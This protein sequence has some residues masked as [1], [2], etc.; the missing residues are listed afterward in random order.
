[1]KLRTILKNG[2][3]ISVVLLCGSR[4]PR[5]PYAS[6]ISLYESLLLS[7]GVLCC[8]LGIWGSVICP[9]ALKRASDPERYR[10]AGAHASEVLTPLFLSL[11]LFTGVTLIVF[12]APL[13]RG[14]NLSWG[15]RLV[16]KSFAAGLSGG[17]FFV[18]CSAVFGLMGLVDT[19]QSIV[20]RTETETK[21]KARFMMGHRVPSENGK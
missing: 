18:L 6:I 21:M 5:L 1:M 13:L 4:G 20:T 10:G 11:A 3:L 15:M 14:L 17:I 9:A 8:V 12:C 7:L 19:F 16:I 2:L